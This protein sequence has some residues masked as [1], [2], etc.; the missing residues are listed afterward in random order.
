VAEQREASQEGFY[1]MELVRFEWR[2][3]TSGDDHMPEKQYVSWGGV[4]WGETES[5]WYVGH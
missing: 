1:S 5:T 3:A 2:R 4:G